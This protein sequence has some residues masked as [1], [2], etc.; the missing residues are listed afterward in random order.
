MSDEYSTIGNKSLKITP[1]SNNNCTV[2]VTY[3][4][5]EIDINKS[6]VFSADV[7]VPNEEGICRLFIRPNSSSGTAK[8]M[9]SIVIPENQSTR[10]IMEYNNISETDYSI[11]IRLGNNTVTTEYITNISL[12][13][14]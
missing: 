13:I 2:D 14:Q 3:I 11:F 4:I 8:Q 9:S 6:A 12:Y 5:N 10:I 7:Y 1:N